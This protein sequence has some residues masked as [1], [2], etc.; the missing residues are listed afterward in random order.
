MATIGKTVCG[1]LNQQGGTVVWGVSASGEPTDIPN[2]EDKRQKLIEYLMRNLIPRPLLSVSIETLQKKRLLLIEIP[3]SEDKP[4][5]LKREIWVRV[6]RQNLRATGDQSSRMVQLS[7][8]R[9]S[10]WGRDILPGFE[11]ADCDQAELANARREIAK[12]GRLPAR[13]GEPLAEQ[14]ARCEKFLIFSKKADQL[15][16]RIH[17]EKQFNRKVALN[18]ELKPLQNEIRAL[19]AQ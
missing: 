8:V 2:A 12:A 3:A 10:R 1:M 16:S 17:R 13:P 7:V 5:S 9:S 4:Y 19:S 14:V 15:A 6:G 18:E 11:L